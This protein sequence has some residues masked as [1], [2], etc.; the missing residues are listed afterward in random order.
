[1]P[2][3]LIRR[4]LPALVAGAVAAMVVALR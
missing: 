4:M 1:M 2:V 3:A